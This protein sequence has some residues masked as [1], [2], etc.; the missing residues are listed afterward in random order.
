MRL[1]S[2]ILKHARSRDAAE[3]GVWSYAP[4]QNFVFYF[5]KMDKFM[6]IQFFI[7]LKGTKFTWKMCNVLKSMKNQ[8]S[9]FYFLGYGRFCTKIWSFFDEFWVKKPTITHKIKIGKLIFIPFSN[10]EEI[11]FYIFLFSLDGTLYTPAMLKN[12]K[13][14]SF[15]LLSNIEIPCIL[16]SCFICIAKDSLC[17]EIV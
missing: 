17:D 13:I 10:K 14:K 3:G 16:V 4:Q 15:T 9:D 8:F 1:G 6:G 5:I 2:S 7:Y 12:T 11:Y